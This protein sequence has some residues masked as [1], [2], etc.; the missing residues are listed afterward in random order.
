[1][2]LLLRN[3][4]MH[5]RGMETF[6]SSLSLEEIPI[7]CISLDRRPDRWAQFQQSAKHAGLS[8]VQRL[9]AVDATTFEAHKHPSI[10][11]LTAHNIYNKTRRSHYEIDAPGAVG[12]SLSHI[13]AWEQLRSSGAPAMIVFEDDVELPADIKPRIQKLI[14]MLPSLGG[15]DLVQFHK[16]RFSKESTGCKP[17]PGKKPWERC[18]SLMGAHS[19]MISQRGASQLLKKALPIEMHIDAYMA[20]MCRMKYIEMVWHPLVD[21]KE[22]RKDSDITHGDYS[23]LHIPSN[24]EKFGL[25]TLTSEEVLRICTMAAVVGGIVAYRLFSCRR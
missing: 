12:A 7:V 8:S 14:T 5:F 11:L 15:W 18:T 6:S 24:M 3:L 21:L 9:S 1:M 13:R 20:F 10:S 4:S 17:I 25:V 23:I 16:T 22:P 19:Y 2:L